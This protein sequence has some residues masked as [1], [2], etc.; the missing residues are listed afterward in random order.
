MG[1]SWATYCKHA[2]I[3][4]WVDNDADAHWS[5]WD[6]LWR[7]GRAYSQ[8]KRLRYTTLGWQDRSEVG[9]STGESTGEPIIEP[10]GEPTGQP[11]GT[12]RSQE[13]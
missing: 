5:E 4:I 9:E 2:G 8:A 1:E 13:E 10:T 12:R 3:W 7:D 6:R 11:T